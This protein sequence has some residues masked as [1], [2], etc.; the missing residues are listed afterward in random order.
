M[1]P[2]SLSHVPRSRLNDWLCQGMQTKLT[3]LRGSPRYGTTA[4]V[5]DPLEEKG[6][7]IFCYSLEPGEKDPRRIYRSLTTT[8]DEVTLGLLYNA[9][10]ASQNA[11]PVIY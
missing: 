3:L 6:N 11:K 7:P 1:Q 2:P 9:R 10:L 8:Q 5:S 4:S